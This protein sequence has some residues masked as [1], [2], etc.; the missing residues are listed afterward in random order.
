MNIGIK[1]NTKSLSLLLVISLLFIQCKQEE[2]KKVNQKEEVQEEQKKKNENENEFNSFDQA[3]IAFTDEGSGDAVILLHGFISSGSSWNKTELKKQLLQK[4]Y[5]V[6]VPDLRG[7]GKSEKSHSEAFYKDEAETKDL[8]AL[9]DH[10]NLESYKIVGYSRGSIVLAKLLSMD[11]RISKAVIGGMG[12][13]FADADW[14]KRKM[15]A[16]AFS[17]RVEPNETISG[18]IKYAS[19]IGADLKILGLLQDY[20]PVTP[21]SELNKIKTPIL[22]VC[23]DQDDEN[24]SPQELQKQLPNS[25]LVIIEATHNDTYKQNNFAEVVLEFLNK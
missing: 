7:N 3:K 12:I 24:G 25:K 1:L 22:L 18:A 16:D 13:D 20:Q 17:G 21:I 9:M 14:L 10:L 11:T 6:V 2:Q 23:G 15:F 19:S 8:I 4:G 5:R